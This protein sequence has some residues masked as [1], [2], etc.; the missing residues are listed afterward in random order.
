MR[1]YNIKDDY[2]DFLKRFDSK[3]AENKCETRPYV[4]IVLEIDGIKYYAPFTSP[5][6]KHKNMKNGKDFRKINNGIYG[7]INFNNMIPVVD[8]ALIEIDISNLKNMKYKNLLKNQ[9]LYVNKDKM[10]IQK[11]ARDLHTLILTDTSKLSRYEASVKARCC[12]L[13]ILEKEYINYAGD[14]PTDEN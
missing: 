13:K 2:I 5:K 7:A 11:T 1:F 8:A 14:E 3:V 10:Q 4:G 12:D 6:P 9:L